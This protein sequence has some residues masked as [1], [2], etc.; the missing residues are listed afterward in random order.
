MATYTVDV[1]LKW[2]VKPMIKAARFMVW[3]RLLPATE[4]LAEGLG[5]FIAKHGI[6]VR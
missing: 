5:V 4:E 6:T 2:W 1:R 3:A